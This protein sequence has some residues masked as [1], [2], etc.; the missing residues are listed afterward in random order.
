[1]RRLIEILYNRRNQVLIMKITALLNCIMFVAVAAEYG[2]GKQLDDSVVASTTDVSPAQVR[3]VD[4]ALEPY[5][6]KFE[7]E[8]DVAVD[9]PV[10][11]ASILPTDG[12]RVG[13]CVTWQNGA[14]KI[15]IDS[16]YWQYCNDAQA[17]Q[18]VY[19]ELGHCAL[20]LGH[21][22]R[23]IKFK[24]EDG[25]WPISIMRTTAFN[26]VEIEVYSKHRDYYVQE[27]KP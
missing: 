17:E 3:Q 22:D 5:V 4:P 12:K 23:T 27:L 19:H 1:M 2:C 6:S 21:D 9:Y 11:F 20:G 7:K 8:F 15:M 25:D 14:R 24:D 18:L 26:K 13:Q 16:T 10:T